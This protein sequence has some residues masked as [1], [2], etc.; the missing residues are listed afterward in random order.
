MGKNLPAKAGD[1]RDIGSIPGSG[2]SPG[3]GN[4]NPFQYSCLENPMDRGDLWAKVHTVTKG[5]KRLSMQA[6]YIAKIGLSYG[7]SGKEPFCQG[8][9]QE[10]RVQSLGQEDPLKKEMVTHSS[11]LAW[12]IPCMEEPGGL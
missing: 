6:Q 3:G 4:G 9:R 1:M 5:W 10:M 7:A 8:K 11:T 2:R 12:K